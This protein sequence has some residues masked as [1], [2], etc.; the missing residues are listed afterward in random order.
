[1]RYFAL[2]TDYDGTLAE[3]GIVRSETLRS[4]ERLRNSGR[5]LI[6]VSGRLL[7][8]LK[9]VFPQYEIFQQIVAEN[10]AVLYNTKTQS[11]NLL[12]EAPPDEF[13]AVLAS[14]GVEPLEIGRVIVATL[15]T[16]KQMVLQ[17]IEELGLE[18]QIIFNKGAAMVLPSGVNKATGLQ[19]ALKRLGLSA[20]NTVGV[21]DAEHDHAFLKV[22]ERSV[23]VANALASLKA[24]TD[25]VTRGEA[26]IGV[27]ELIERLL[28]DDLA[29]VQAR[30][31]RDSM[32][33]GVADGRALRVPVYGTSLL[34][35]RDS[36][37]EKSQV[38]TNVMARLTEAGYQ[39]LAFD[40]RGDY[41]TFEGAILVGD[42]KRAPLIDEVLKTLATSGQSL[43][44]NL[45]GVPPQKRPLFFE[46]LVP[47]L[48][49]MRVRT[50][51][52][53]W[54]ILDEVDH[55]MPVLQ[56]AIE[57]G[58]IKGLTGAVLI[59]MEPDRLPPTVLCS[60][61]M[62]VA[63]G[64]RQE[65]TIRTFCSSCDQQ[66]P[67][68]PAIRPEPGRALLWSRKRGGAPISVQLTATEFI[69]SPQ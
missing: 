15:D 18:L 33:L 13:A 27:V 30:D 55:L 54:V 23:A 66:C 37:G 57:A 42:R 46:S 61:D 51:R 47:R 4:L 24:K 11:E 26:G 56:R 64:E 14:K 1:M 19:A 38:S 43:I 45:L 36:T 69:R 16:H 12:C 68:L 25:L 60:L 62:I 17:T 49:E 22:C 63:V 20:H 39:F 3:E 6:L 41:Q 29:S 35:S 40:P 31:E 59:A 5:Q 9:A 52:P 10:G 67:P 65:E 44:V 8:D 53:H 48:R 28:A 34:I 7:P 50:G 32:V 21:G 58:P 2:A